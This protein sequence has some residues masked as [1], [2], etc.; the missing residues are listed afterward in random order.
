LHAASPRQLW[1]GALPYFAWL[2]ICLIY[3]SGV[4]TRH[5]FAA[6]RCLSLS[7]VTSLAFGVVPDFILLD[8]LDPTLVFLLLG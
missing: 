1:L 4:L 5:G 3:F 7:F 2:S 8:I 6:R